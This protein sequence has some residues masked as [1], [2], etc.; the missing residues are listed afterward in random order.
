MKNFWK[1]KKVLVTG[2]SGF[3]GSHAVSVLVNNG[4]KVTATVSPHTSKRIIEELFENTSIKVVHADLLDQKVCSKIFLGHEIVL[5]FAALD[6]GRAFKQKYPA[7][8]FVTNSTITLNVL[9]AARKA[10]IKRLML[11]SSIEVYP[12]VVRSPVREEYAFEGSPFEQTEGYAWSKRFSEI[13][14]KMY[15]KEYGIPITIIR[16]GN[17]YGP[18]DYV[19]EGKGRVIPTFITKVLQGEKITLIGDGL[20][21]KSFLYVTDFINACLSL[22]E[23]YAT[24]E[25]VN[26]AGSTYISIKDLALLISKITLKKAQFLNLPQIGIM[27]KRVIDIKKV[28]SLISYEEKVS[29]E[30]G[31]RQTIEYV[32]KQR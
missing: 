10:K 23:K 9:E 28:K 6:G 3:I 27:E 4:A 19:D 30:E 7:K 11:M 26:V 1:N 8:I 14:A 25:A 20:Q 24:S 5:N 31:L 22:T 15:Y 18:G 17:V 21:E 16:A 2:A 29:L 12:A 13:A 32:K